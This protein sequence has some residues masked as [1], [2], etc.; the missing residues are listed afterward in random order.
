MY[1][2]YRYAPRDEGTSRV[3]ARSRAKNR[4]CWPFGDPSS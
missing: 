2:V 3:A 1:T 4:N